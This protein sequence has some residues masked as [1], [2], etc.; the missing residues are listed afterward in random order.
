M[1]KDIKCKAA[2]GGTDYDI[3]V[4]RTGKKYDL[5]VDGKHCSRLFLADS[6]ENQEIDVIIGGKVCQFVL[7]GDEPDLSVDG[8]LQFAEWEYQKTRKFHRQ[9]ALWGGLMMILVGLLACYAWVGLTASGGGALGGWVS[10][11]M[12]VGFT[13]IGIWLVLHSRKRE[14]F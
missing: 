8:I 1:K 3:R 12:S 2:V 9:T 10:L 13:L 4:E 6:G 7:Y 11:V 14:E 5:Y